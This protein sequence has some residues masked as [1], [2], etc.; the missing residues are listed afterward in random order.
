M[1]FTLR[2]VVLRI[3]KLYTSQDSKF[4]NKYPIGN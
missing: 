2:K 4:K 1:C 3:Q